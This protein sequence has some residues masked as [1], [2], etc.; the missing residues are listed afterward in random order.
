MYAIAHIKGFQ[1]KVQKGETLRVPSYD[2][3]VGKKVTIP[4]VM[5]VASDDDIMV[6]APYVEQAVIEATVTE[7]DRYDKITIFKKKR[8][9]DY[10]V[11]RGHRQGF[12]VLTIDDIVV[13]KAKKKARTDK[14]KAT[15]EAASADETSES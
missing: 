13:G 9:K 5:L 2:L 15:A 7:H 8:R 3:E 1:Y 4:E 14:P 12:T 11:K 6:G 10:S